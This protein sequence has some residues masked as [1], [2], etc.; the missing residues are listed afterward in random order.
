ME[1]V[2]QSKPGMRGMDLFDFITVERQENI[3]EEEAKVI[4]VQ[5]V[6]A[7]QFLHENEVYI[8][9]CGWV[10]G[11]LFFF[12]SFICI[13]HEAVRSI[14]VCL[15]CGEHFQHNKITSESIYVWFSTNTY[16]H[17]HTHTYIHTGD[18]WGYQTRERH[19]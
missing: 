18:S 4:F 9:I 11:L 19:A 16:T 5:L 2:G 8:Y 15:S 13:F 14:D 6:Q 7:L 12:N 10:G 1:L 17:T 3:E